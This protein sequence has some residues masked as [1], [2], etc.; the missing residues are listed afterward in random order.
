VGEKGRSEEGRGREEEGK[1]GEGR[2]SGLP[3]YTQFLG[4]PLATCTPVSSSNG[5]RSGLEAVGGVPCRQ[6][7]AATLLVLV[8]I[9]QP[10]PGTQ[11]LHLQCA[12]LLVT[13]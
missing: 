4:T 2:R 8:C 3:P 10:Q 13:R 1:E 5:Q 11:Q 12:S 7:P 9:G 6:N